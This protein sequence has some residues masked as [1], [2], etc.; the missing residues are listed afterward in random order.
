MIVYR[1]ASRQVDPA[2]ELSRCLTMTVEDV[3]ALTSRLIGL[4]SLEAALTDQWMPDRDGVDPR[5]H[6]LG[7]ATRAAASALLQARD[8]QRPPADDD[9]ERGVRRALTSALRLVLPTRLVLRVPEG[10]AYYGV[11]PLAYDEAVKTYLRE[12]RPQQVLVVGVRTIGATLGAVVAARCEREGLPVTTVTVRPKGHPY[13]RRCEVDAGWRSGVGPHA[14]GTTCFVVDEGPGLSGSSLTSVAELLEEL[15]HAADRIVFVCSHDPVSSSLR[16]M[17]ARARWT[18]HVRLVASMQGPLMAEDWS[19]GAWRARLGWPSARWPPVHP[20]HE[21]HK[22]IDARDPTRLLKFVGL[23]PYGRAVWRR[24][25]QAAAAGFTVPTYDMRDGYLAMACVH[26]ARP[27]GRRATPA[28]ATALVRYLSWRAATQQ[29]GASAD[30]VAAM[31]LLEHNVRL[32]HGGRLDEGLARVATAVQRAAAQPAVIV[33]G[34]LAPW[35]W[36]QTPRGLLKVDT[37]EHG[38]DHF[39]PGPQ[40]IGWDVAGALSEFAWTPAE[41]QALLERLAVSLRDRT[42]ADRMQWL[43]P[44]YLAARLGYASLAAES[45]TESEEGSRFRRARDRYA[46]QLARE[47]GPR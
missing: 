19:A 18:R 40:D 5:V 25:T 41:R 37:A 23:G 21:R 16:S 14:T 28:L 7:A 20:Q 39:Q 4:G 33:D 45:L 17:R 29:T 8:Q 43:L 10:F 42:L 46:R 47:L 9:A 1:D 38:D 36:L 32:H 27:L 44:C 26:D 31:H 35:E 34:H 2:L 24:A 12:A 3:D 15:G 22:G 13:D 6:T 11:H 30:A